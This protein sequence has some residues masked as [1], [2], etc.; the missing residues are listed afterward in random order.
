[1]LSFLA[2]HVWLLP[3]SVLRLRS[4]LPTYPT[5]WACAGYNRNNAHQIL[6]FGD[7]SP[8]FGGTPSD[9]SILRLCQELKARGYKV[10][11]YPMLQV[12]TITPLSKPWRGRITPTTSTAANGFFTR[13][14]GYNA[15]IN[16]Y[17][18]LQ[19][20]GVYL[21]NYLDA[22]MIGSELVGLTTYMSSAGV[23]P[24]VTQ[25]KGL[26]A[27]VKGAVGSGVKVIAYSF[28]ILYALVK[29]L[30]YQ[31]VANSNLVPFV[32]LH[33]TL[34]SEDDAAIFAGIISFYFGQRAMRK[35]GVSK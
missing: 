9:I 26:A 32:V 25:L 28:F 35:L 5:D 33:D 12:D 11:L 22:F 24:A 3:S 29:L 6:H 8:T 20:G 21:K 13:T 14:L 2:T 30:A 1:M 17:A 4:C 27:S 31:A 23:F 7:G 10:L 18:N 34:W 19:I 15:F 16:W